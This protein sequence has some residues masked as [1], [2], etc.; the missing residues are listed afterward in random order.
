MT[1]LI[2]HWIRNA[3]DLRALVD[4]LAGSK[5]VALDTESDSLHHYKEKVCLVQLATE[6]GASH[7]IDPLAFDDLSALAPLCADPGIVKI[8]H[9]AD[10]DLTCL[11]RDFGFHFV[12]L[13]DTMIASRTLGLTEIGLDAVLLKY[14]QVIPGKSRQRDDWSERPL[15]PAQEAYAITDVRYLIPLRERLLADLRAMGREAWVLEECEAVAA[16]P[17]GGRVFDPDGFLWLKGSRQLDGRQLA[18][19][20]ALYRDRE[21]W[22]E[23]ADRPVFKVLGNE[24]LVHLALARPRTP[25]SLRRIRGCSPYVLRKYG[26]GIFEAIAQGEALPE[27]E[28][29]TYPES[30]R[31]HV[32][33]IV[34]RRGERLKKWREAA[35][36]RFGLDPGI[37]LPQRL[38]DRLA[39]E[40]P[41][42]LEALAKVEG[43]RRW[44]AHTFG[45]EVLACMPDPPAH[46]GAPRRRRRRRPRARRP[47]SP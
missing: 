27:S 45:P 35:A 8:F 36:P 30:P 24:T 6:A 5:A 29:P 1:D 40:G 34:Q 18:V 44:R 15:S 22:A 47:Q 2:A 19:L 13:F 17:A 25:E 10:Y 37:L 26:E 20:R 31:R 12:N 32:S 46:E 23:A 4:S 33:G 39:E 43:F 38:I 41:A 42:D 11:K 9:A 14:F 21:R 28:F 7:L 3:E 16:I